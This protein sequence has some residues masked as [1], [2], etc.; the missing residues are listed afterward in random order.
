M[1]FKEKIESEKPREKLKNQGISSLTDSELLSI[2]LRT[3]SKNESVD[4]LATKILKE[5]GGLNKLNEITLNNLTKIKGIKL[6]KAST[7]LV[8][9]ELGKRLLKEN[10]KI[11]KIKEPK[12]IFNYFKNQFIGVKQETFFVLLY[13]T[14]MNLIDKKELYKGTIDSVDA[15]P[16]EVFK[17]AIMASATFIIIMH[18]HPSGDTTP[19]DEDIEITNRLI[20]TG[21]IIGIKIL[22]HIIISNTSYFSFYE[23]SLKNKIIS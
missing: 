18:N 22:D 15:H 4:E 7:I 19:S 11:T 12:E 8:A 21:H 14:K 2:L 3:G 16:R 9:I 1:K 17:E 6:S 5:I 10:Q 13:D 23:N 20:E